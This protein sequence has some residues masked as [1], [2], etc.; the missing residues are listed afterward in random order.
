MR[1]FEPW[2]EFALAAGLRCRPL[3]VRHDGGATFGFRL[4]G[5]R[6]L[7]GQAAAVGYVAD[8]G[9]WDD[10]LA[11][12]LADVD[13]LAVEFNHDV[14][15]EYAS[16][17]SPRLIDRVL[18]D[19][20]HLSNAQGAGLVRAVLARSE[21]GAR[22]AF[23]PA[24][25]EPRM[26]PADPGPRGGAG[27][28]GRIGRARRSPHGPQ[29]EPGATLH[30]GA[31]RGVRRR[32]RRPTESASAPRRRGGASAAAGVGRKGRRVMARRRSA[33]AAERRPRSVRHH[34]IPH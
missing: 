33:G 23:G 29:D 11:G 14:A 22:A 6:D 19:E 15:M 27:G 20:G 34:V 26:Q 17:R 13:L 24:A 30:L 31:G 7:F 2:Q 8:L 3:P 10:D 4:E 12:G 28:A 9:C 18:G 21:T 5:G 25:P 1:P 16:G 32:P